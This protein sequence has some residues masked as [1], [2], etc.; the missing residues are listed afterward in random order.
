MTSATNHRLAMQEL[1]AQEKAARKAEKERQK[2]V[3]RDEAAERRRAAKS[4]FAN[5][6][7]P[8]RSTLMTVLCSLFAIYC[9][10]PFVYL[11]IN[12][13]KS[14]ADFTSTF[15]LWFGGEFNLWDNIVTVF[16]YQDGIFGR[17]FLNTILYVVVGAGG[18]TLLAIM[19]GY[20]LAKFR[21][22]GRKAVFAVII[23]SISVPGTA[24]AVPQFLL[25]AQLGLTNTPWSMIIPSLISPFGLYLM[26]IFSEQ[27]VPTELL[28]AARVD[29]AGEFRTFFR[30]SLPLLAPGIVT[31][32]LFTIVATWNNYF[33]PLIML[34]DA[35][36]YPLTIGLN[37]W[38]DQANTAGGTA[39]QNLVITGSLITIIPLVIA[40]LLLQKYWQSG[41]AA[42]AVKE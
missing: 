1:K 40:F 33:L 12:A 2:R 5:V 13:T 18:A 34:K 9:L 21:F 38:K 3:A 24:L 19:G 25:F 41:L 31:T 30:V 36:W 28:E 26:W 35:D 4:G 10:F 42:G 11:L 16:T 8:R 14:Q 27:A 6:A 22:P 17:W 23:G 7:N 20:A 37:Q 39:I 29:G 15:G 32:S